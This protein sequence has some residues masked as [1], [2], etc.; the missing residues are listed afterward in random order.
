MINK[1]RTALV[2]GTS[3]GIG[4]YIARELAKEGLNLVLAAR[5][6]STLDEVADEIHRM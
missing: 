3:Q 6:A 2:T 5:S 4:P 1:Y